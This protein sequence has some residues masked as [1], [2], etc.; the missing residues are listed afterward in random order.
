[1]C[2]GSSITTS[3]I[4][5]AIQH[6]PPESLQANRPNAL[7]DGCSFLSARSELR[8]VDER[9]AGGSPA[10]PA[11]LPADYVV[12]GFSIS[13]RLTFEAAAADRRDPETAR[14]LS[15]YRCSI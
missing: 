9:P 2:R 12:N 7:G 15:K 3:G 11:V 5:L 13:A 10:V 6:W 14:G 8:V 1:M 4:S